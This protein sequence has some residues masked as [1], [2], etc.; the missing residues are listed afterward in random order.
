MLLQVRQVWDGAETTLTEHRRVDV[1]DFPEPPRNQTTAQAGPASGA[2]LR[3]G[4]RR[5]TQKGA[6]EQ[7][8]PLSDALA[9]RRLRCRRIRWGS[10]S[11]VGSAGAFPLVTSWCE[12]AR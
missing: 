2:G 9:E 3:L 1:G 10:C 4:R 7:F 12:R 11:I 6:V 5:P 8:A